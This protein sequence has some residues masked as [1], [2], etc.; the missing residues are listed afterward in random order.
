M[1]KSRISEVESYLSQE[2][3][4]KER[5][6]L[7]KAMAAD[8][9]R[10]LAAMKDINARASTPGLSK[11]EAEGLRRGKQLNRYLLKLYGLTSNGKPRQPSR[12]ALEPGRLFLKIAE[13]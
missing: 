3:M 9:P 8:V 12:R 1:R 11:E 10:A 4:A 7:K 2:K 13:D 6:A 5:E